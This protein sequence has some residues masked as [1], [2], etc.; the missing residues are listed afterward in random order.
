MDEEEIDK[1]AIET[2]GKKLQVIVTVEELSE[3]SKEL[4]K[5]LRKSE[6]GKIDNRILEACNSRILEEMADV[7]IM[8][9]QLK[10]IFNNKERF[11]S[12]KKLKLE[13]VENWLSKS[14]EVMTHIENKN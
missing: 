10:M 4:M 7:E 9:N 8:L 3:L 11:E 12:Y 13:K 1:K 14:K 2:W 5:Y 6:L